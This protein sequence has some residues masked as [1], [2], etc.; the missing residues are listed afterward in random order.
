MTD[1]LDVALAQRA[2]DSAPPREPTADDRALLRLGGWR[3]TEAGWWRDPEGHR[4]YAW[5]RALRVIA[6]DAARGDEPSTGAP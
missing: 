6:R 1:S 5:Q 2:L 3:E 4:R